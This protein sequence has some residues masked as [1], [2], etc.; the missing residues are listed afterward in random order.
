M[1]VVDKCMVDSVVA[2]LQDN[3]DI[4]QYVSRCLGYRTRAVSRGNLH[5]LP[6]ILG[7]VYQIWGIRL[8]VNHNGDTMVGLSSEMGESDWDSV[9]LFSPEINPPKNASIIRRSWVWYHLE[10]GRHYVHETREDA[11]GDLWDDFGLIPGEGPPYN[12]EHPNGWEDDPIDDEE[13]ERMSHMADEEFEK[14][15]YYNPKVEDEE[16]QLFDADQEEW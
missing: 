13:A 11:L 1:P 9:V 12:I 3:R 2:I 16:Q 15:S 6:K 4:L 5:L 8:G 7:R 14:E 10:A